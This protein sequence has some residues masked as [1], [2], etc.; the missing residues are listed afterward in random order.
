[1][2]AYL[3]RGMNPR[4]LSLACL[5]LATACD[6]DTSPPARPGPDLDEDASVEPTPDAGERDAG[7]TDAGNRDAGGDGDGCRETAPRFSAAFAPDGR[8][9]DLAVDALDVHLVY[10]ETTCAGGNGDALGHQLRY[11]KFATTGEVPDAAALPAVPSDRCAKIRDPLLT[12]EP[13]DPPRP[14][15]HFLSTRELAWDAYRLAADDPE[16]EILRISDPATTHEAHELVGTR[17]SGGAAHDAGG[18]TPAEARVAL[19][20]GVAAPAQD[21]QRG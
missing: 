2:K 18:H 13:G 21:E 20:A 4:H 14:V 12:L 6:D 1:M 9:F 15:V 7:Y 16:A 19:R 3:G 17:D 8:G 10:V 11:A 5:L